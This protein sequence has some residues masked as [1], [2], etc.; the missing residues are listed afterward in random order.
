MSL[1]TMKFPKASVNKKHLSKL[2]RNDRLRGDMDT[3]T[4]FRDLKGCLVKE[5]ADC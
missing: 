4:L 3:R 2:S 1:K 5:G